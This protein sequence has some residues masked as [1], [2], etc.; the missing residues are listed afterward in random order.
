MHPVKRKGFVWLDKSAIFKTNCE[1]LDYT[2]NVSDGQAY[3]CVCYYVCI[4]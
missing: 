4:Q 2:L 1:V 3:S